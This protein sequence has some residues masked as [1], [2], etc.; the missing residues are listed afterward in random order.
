MPW[1]F[2][3][4][5][6]SWQWATRK[7][8]LNTTSQLVPGTVHKIATEGGRLTC[9]QH[10][11]SPLSY[12]AYPSFCLTS[13]CPKCLIYRLSASYIK[14]KKGPHGTLCP[15]SH[16]LCLAKSSGKLDHLQAS[17][18]CGIKE[19]EFKDI[20]SPESEVLLEAATH[21]P[22]QLK[23]AQQVKR[24]DYHICIHVA[25]KKITQ[26]LKTQYFRDSFTLHM[27][28]TN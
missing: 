10:Y 11:L 4:L 20:A 5:L 16:T 6:S 25:D 22:F 27:P 17:I 8:P 3:F 1:L 12:P 13:K 7:T 26:S 9:W 28:S 19:W 23:Q 14:E 24:L 2:P 15:R 18:L 21:P